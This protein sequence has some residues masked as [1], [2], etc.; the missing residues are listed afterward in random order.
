MVCSQDKGSL[1]CRGTLD[2]KG[3]PYCAGVIWDA[4]TVMDIGGPGLH[5][6]AAVG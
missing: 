2:C 4:E 6:T 1:S 3:S 5:G